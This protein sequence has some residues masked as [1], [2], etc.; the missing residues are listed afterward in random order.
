MHSGIGTGLG[1]C[2]TVWVGVSFGIFGVLF[3]FSGINGGFLIPLPLNGLPKKVSLILVA[4]GSQEMVAI[5]ARAGWGL[6]G[7]W[8]GRAGRAGRQAWQAGQVGRL[9]GRQGRLAGTQA[10]QVGRQAGGAGWQEDR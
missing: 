3:G 7:Y 6:A 8:A 9:A 1:D 2:G 4:S 10:G 5:I